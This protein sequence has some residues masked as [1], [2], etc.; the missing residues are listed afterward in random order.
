MHEACASAAELDAALAAL[1]ERMDRCAPEAMAATQQLIALAGTVSVEDHLD[2]A[3]HA[4]VKAV[5]G[6]E[7]QEGSAAFR[8]KRKPRWG[9][10][11]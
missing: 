4:F 2:T 3:S 11:S 9:Q 10:A 7:G 6:P 5:R 8:D 1:L